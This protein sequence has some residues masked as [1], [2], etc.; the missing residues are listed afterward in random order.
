MNIKGIFF[1][2]FRRHVKTSWSAMKVF[3]RLIISLQ[4]KWMLTLTMIKILR[5]KLPLLIMLHI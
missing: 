1:C 5:V 2:F 4:H 3:V